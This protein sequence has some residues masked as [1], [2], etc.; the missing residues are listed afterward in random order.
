MIR[1]KT[2][3]VDEDIESLLIVSDIHAFKQP[4]DAFDKI[5]SEWAKPF[6]IVFNGDL[7]AGGVC[8]DHAVQWVIEKVGAFA[9]LGNH[10]EAMLNSQGVGSDDPHTESGAYRRLTD[11]QKAYFRSLPHRLL[12]NWR[13]QRIGLMHGHINQHGEPG[14]WL[15]SPDEVIR[16]FSDP[17]VDLSITGH[18]HFPFVK[19]QGTTIYANSGSLSATILGIVHDGSVVVSHGGQHC[20]DHEDARSSF[21]AVRMDNGKLQVDVVR[22]DYDRAAAINDMKSAGRRRID[23]LERL[24]NQGVLE[25]VIQPF[26]MQT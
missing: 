8:P 4:L 20:L 11:D 3:Q 13:G 25:G 2:I 21:L 9:T 7:F 1:E 19:R 14:S 15:Q 18:T 5:C 23:L 22:F 10:D 17:E 16:R 12:L 6:Q 24:I 26:W